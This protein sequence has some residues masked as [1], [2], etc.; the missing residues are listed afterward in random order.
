MLSNKDIVLYA[1]YILGGWQTR[2][3]TEDIAIKC[4]QLVPRKFSWVKYPQYPDIMPTI[5]GLESAKKLKNGA[6]VEGESERKR[7]PKRIGG[8]ML[9]PNGI[10]WIEANK[11]RVEEYLSKHEIIGDRLHADRK[12]KELYRSKAFRK[13]IKNGEKTE[14]SHAEFAESL[15][16]TVNTRSK[17]LKDRLKQLH[18]I[19]EKLKKEEIKNY[20]NF[21]KKEFESLLGRR[22]E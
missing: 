16:C 14:I 19:A 7:T 13:F 18:S 6:L 4:H 11:K 22:G 15:I 8:W 17:I 9:T 3:H 12:L 5:F 20:V 10:N 21:C 2:I 1:L